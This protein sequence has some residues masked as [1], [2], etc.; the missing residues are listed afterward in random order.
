MDPIFCSAIREGSKTFKPCLSRTGGKQWPS[1]IQVISDVHK[2]PIRQLICKS[3]VEVAPH[4]YFSFCEESILCRLCLLHNLSS[5]THSLSLTH[6]HRHTHT[7]TQTHTHT[8]THL[9][10][11]CWCLCSKSIRYLMDT[12]KS[13]DCWELHA[14]GRVWELSAASCWSVTDSTLVLVLTTKQV[15]PTLTLKTV[16][17]LQHS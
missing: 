6:T 2:I 5:H 3:T 4:F 1:F 7:H 11:D 16:K 12:R 8:H 17:R 9:W 14:D 15:Y 13:A 10:P